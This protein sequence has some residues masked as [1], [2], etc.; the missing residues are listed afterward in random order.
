M[1]SLRNDFGSDIAEF[2]PLHSSLISIQK[3]S[4]QRFLTGSVS[5]LGAV[6]SSIDG[7]FSTV[8][9]VEDSL[10]RARIDF[11]SSRLEEP[12]YT[13][14]EC[15]RKALTYSSDLY[16]TVAITLFEFDPVTGVAEVRSIKEQEVFLL[17]MPLM[18]DSATFIV[19][20]FERVVVSQM[21]RSPGV[22]FAR[23]IVDNVP[24]YS[25]SIIPYR[26][27]WITL[28][29]DSK[30]SLFFKIDKKRKLSVYFLLRAFGMDDQQMLDYY[31][32]PLNVKFD[33][34]KNMWSL[35]LSPDEMLGRYSLF[36]IFN[37]NGECVCKKDDMITKKVVRLLN[38]SEYYYCGK[39][40]LE[41][42]SLLKPVVMN[43]QPLYDLSFS[44]T[45][46]LIDE[47]IEN[48]IDNMSLIDSSLNSY[49]NLILSIVVA[50]KGMSKEDV[51]SSLFKVLYA[52]EPFSL[53]EAEKRFVDSFCSPVYYD[54][55]PVGRYKMNVALDIN[56]LDDTYRTLRA[57][58]LFLTIKK[59]IATK[60]NKDQVDD[61][62][63]L[64]NRRIRS[65]GELLEN[66]F[67]TGLARTVKSIKERLRSVDLDKVVP[68]MLISGSTISKLVKDFFITSQLSQFM[69]QTNPLAELSHKRRI[70]ALGTGGLTRDR[71]GIEV[72]D[73]HPT[74]YGR[75][76]PIE[77]PEGQ[78]IG[79]ISSLATYSVVN[80]YGF[81]ESPYR[82]VLNRVV[83][84][85]VVYL[86]ATKE[87][88]VCIC[89]FDTG[90][91]E[92]NK[93]T[94]DIV[95]ARKNGE[96]V[97]VRADEVDYID[98]SPRQTISVATSLIP[99]LENDDAKRALMGS[100]MQ[101]QAVPLIET[102][103]PF[104]GTGMES[105]IGVDSGSVVV[106]KRGGEVVL[107]DANKIS[108]RVVDDN[109][110]LTSDSDSYV[111]RKFER[112]NH[113][114]CINQIPA[115]KTGQVVKAGDVIIDGPATS[116]GE[117]A[118]GK[119]LL[120]GIMP[121]NGYNFEDSIVISERVV[122]ED[123]FTSIH[124]EEFDVV[125]RDTRLGVEE[126]TRDIPN[127]SGESVDNLDEN[128]IVHLGAFVGPND[129]LV[130]K[131]TPKS[132]APV[133]PEE[134]LLMAIFGEKASE[135]R[136]S[137]LRVPPGIVGTVVD[138]IIL[139]KRGLEK[140]GRARLIEED[141]LR[142]LKSSYDREV[143]VMHKFFAEE[144]VKLLN[145][146]EVYINFSSKKK[147]T[148]KISKN[149]LKEHKFNE[150][151]HCKPVDKSGLD[152]I[153]DLKKQFDAVSLKMEENFKKKTQK[154]VDGDD[155]Q[156][157]VLKQIKVY[158]AIKNKL[159]P[160]DKMAGRHGNKGVVSKILSVEDMPYMEDGTPL[161][162]VLNPLGVPSRMNI[163]QIL[164][165]NL[166]WAS[167]TVGL[168]INEMIASGKAESEV[169]ELLKNVLTD[170][171]LIKKIDKMNGEDIKSL[172]K[173]CR[174][175]YPFKTPAFEAV[176][177]PGIED[178]FSKI[179]LHKS[180]QIKLYDGLT[181]EPF[182]RPITV[183]YMYILKLHHLINSKI[184]ARSTGSYSLVTQQPLG[185]KSNFGG[186]RL[187]EM[188]C[189]ALQAYGAAHT[190][191]EMLTVK[192]DDVQGRN[193]MYESI[194]K[195]EVKYSYGIPES[196]NVLFKE[197]RALCFNINLEMDN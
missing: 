70:S 136:D 102:E 153:A 60:E 168:R 178:M 55:F 28:A 114:T 116:N 182:D 160:G 10:G 41:G 155:L 140:D 91:V 2:T 165:T 9:P 190:L 7:I 24:V 124:I 131:L 144:I 49:S 170:H 31:Y 16:I 109:G 187:G 93:I 150:I 111:L 21:H 43:E 174:A 123:K 101:R 52:G 127:V 188:E 39:Y 156:P 38:E 82:K 125:V 180:G 166:G 177:V 85:E 8:F 132:D 97:L 115:V 87:S 119:N 3:E 143:D 42:F 51:F 53:D 92:G 78:N 34:S 15:R 149:T 80:K 183:G 189:W 12:K 141:M 196:F 186:Q 11:I 56:D 171:R 64:R 104:V 103:A 84:D 194:V 146:K 69:D 142:N 66:Q 108:I 120:V 29:F 48:G 77:T 147:E 179:G 106:A 163:G 37:A 57:E 95:S 4:Y 40:D 126:V 172:A 161:D 122:Q 184:H 79:L 58:D 6:V 1:Q 173:T 159:Q 23:D 47:V 44:I 96:F 100:N 158:I 20:G 128:G 35:K 167:R 176:K 83:T 13:I 76:C 162:I 89:Q 26:G 14:S 61:I 192:S 154:I 110:N 145:G 130:G 185:G 17:Q 94:R 33:S 137:S 68:D 99:F 65:V 32:K 152:L 175:G 169:K 74:H 117:L 112:S 81:I 195:G 151:V 36:D 59:L 5:D 46:S 138:V 181:G 105:V 193:S 30:S 197:L 135:V 121:W 62:D 133:T 164:E 72:R 129:I 54:L 139:T 90:I 50:H 45:S 113:S 73:V 22:F 98:V 25:A 71:A 18:T 88:N 148:I 134:K 27:S 67:R 157:G 107:V 63:D 75:I 86:D 118:L 19:N 191:Q